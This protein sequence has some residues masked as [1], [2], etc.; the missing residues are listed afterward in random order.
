[1]KG[2]HSEVDDLNGC[3]VKE[4]ERLGT[5][6]PVNAAVVE[7]AHQIESGML[8]PDPSNL[9]LLQARIR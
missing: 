9:A 7:L 5:A 2:R 1:M 3:V 8:R 4:A 6:A